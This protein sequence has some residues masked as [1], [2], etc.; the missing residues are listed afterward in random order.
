[1]AMQL[2][3]LGRNRALAS[4]ISKLRIIPPVRECV[5]AH[6]S[7]CGLQGNTH[8]E[9]QLLLGYLEVHAPEEL[10]LLADTC[11]FFDNIAIAGLD[12]ASLAPSAGVV[13][14]IVAVNY[15]EMADA[16]QDTSY[17]LEAGL[18]ALNIALVSGLGAW[19]V[20]LQ[21]TRTG[22]RV[23]RIYQKIER[24]LASTVRPI[25]RPIRK[26]YEGLLNTLRRAAWRIAPRVRRAI[27]LVE[28][29]VRGSE[30]VPN[31][32]A[33]HVSKSGNLFDAFSDKFLGSSSL[34]GTNV[35]SLDSLLGHCFH[36]GRNTL[37]GYQDR[38]ELLGGFMYK[39][40]LR[41]GKTATI[42]I[43][44]FR[45]AFKNAT[46][47]DV[48]AFRNALRLQGYG[49]VHMVGG[50]AGKLSSD[51]YIALTSQHVKIRSVKNLKTGTELQAKSGP[52]SKQ[53]AALRANPEHKLKAKELVAKYET[54]PV[55]NI[56]EFE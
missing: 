44:E 29:L 51:M 41:L 4:R 3:Q 36:P 35:W 18:S 5:A 26:F 42:D 38:A 21:A 7:A 39:A 24:V 49:G 25:S 32:I 19:V 53:V 8:V 45:K 22:R 40:N 13:D 56:S 54:T 17:D 48:V 9:I 37:Y 1:M 2:V 20:A 50:K 23:V 11:E 12:L 46:A 31:L 33:Y 30:S 52:F 34:G 14:A 55:R 27:P 16:Y 47:A 6:Q 28:R 43:Y 10:A 15:L